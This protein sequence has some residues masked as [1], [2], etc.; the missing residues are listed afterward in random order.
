MSDLSDVVY[1][2]IHRGKGIYTLVSGIAD[3]FIYLHYLS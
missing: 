2:K 1:F 3:G